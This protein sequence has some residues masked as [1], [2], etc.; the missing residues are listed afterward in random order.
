MKESLSRQERKF[1]PCCLPVSWENITLSKNPFPESKDKILIVTNRPFEPDN[2]KGEIYPNSIADFRNV[3]YLIVTCNQGEWEICPVE[4]LF[5]GLKAIDDGEDILLFTHGHGK[6]LRQVLTRSHQIKQKYG[7]SLVVFDWPSLNSNFNLSLARVRRCGHN[8][9]NLLLQLEQYRQS[10]MNTGQNLSMILHSLGNYFLTHMVVNG[11]N[12][13]MRAKIFDNII[14]NAAAIRSKEHGGVISQLQ[15]QDRIYVVF[16]KR[17]FV[18]RGAHLLTSGRMLGNSVMK[19]LASNA[20]YVDFS[21]VAGTEHTYFAGYHD[22]EYEIPAVNAFFHGAFHGKD[23]DLSDR[24]MFSKANETNVI[25][26]NGS[27]TA[28]SKS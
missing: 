26:V 7:I 18:L 12:Q 17:D 15:I 28:K 27:H 24:S 3:S 22:F 1:G 20:I 2:S 16:N 19:P 11:N 5:T 10:E 25:W 14:M 23:V 6:S 21:G 13:Y 4:N 8:F 9:Y